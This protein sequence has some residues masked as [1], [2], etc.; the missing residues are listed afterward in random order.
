MEHA[1]KKKF[2]LDKGNDP[3][4][5]YTTGEEVF[6]AVTHGVGSV[7]AIIG[8]TVL[9]T[10]CALHG[11]LYGVGISLIYG[12][13][14]IILYTMSTLYHSFT[15]SHVKRIFRIFD[16]STIYLLIAGTYTPLTI[17]LMRA[18]TRASVIC[19]AVWILAVIGI[20]L[21]CISITK[22][23]K[24][25]MLLYVGMGWAV[26]FMIN[27]IMSALSPAGFILLLSGGL[28]YTGGIIFYKWNAVR[29]MHGVWHLFVL[30]G[31]A[32]HY[33]CVILYAMPPVWA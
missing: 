3:T 18:S 1:M 31:S 20:I 6:N 8:T 16:H 7:L 5:F 25:S 21:N 9:V 23:E 32:L 24:L 26:V 15:G 12:I 30:A 11:S 33:L 4:K 13:S 14:L 28:C 29:Y 19:A 22:F 17:G 10:V 2:C 27:D